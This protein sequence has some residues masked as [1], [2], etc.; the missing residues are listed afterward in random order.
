MEI[1]GE[2]YAN[3]KCY[4]AD[5]QNQK[6]YVIIKRTYYTKKYLLQ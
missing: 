5:G 1:E 4:P 2:K 6:L 3:Q